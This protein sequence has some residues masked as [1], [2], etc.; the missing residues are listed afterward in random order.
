MQTPSNELSPLPTKTKQKDNYYFTRGDVQFVS[1][2]HTKNIM[3]IRPLLHGV[4]GMK[5]EMW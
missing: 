4:V 5:S 1:I 2:A 3:S